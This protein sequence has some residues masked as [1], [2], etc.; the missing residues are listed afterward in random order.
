[1]RARAASVAAVASLLLI[2]L[3]VIAVA[4]QQERHQLGSN[5][6]RPVAFDAV[7]DP[8]EELCQA[9]TDVPRGTGAVLLRLRTSERS[10]P[11]V[12]LTIGDVR[13]TLPA[14]WQDGDV[15]VPVPALGAAREDAAVC[16]AHD[17][18]G[19]IAVAGGPGIGEPARVD[20]R[21][22]RADGMIRLEFAEAGRRSWFPVVG[23]IGDRLDGARDAL[24]G[25]AALPLFVL[26]ALGV[27]GGSL[28][29]VVRE[30]RR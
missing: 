22:V 1:V 8:E 20:G 24:P 11:A 18:P 17:G 29:L 6:V 26:L 3:G 4:A 19:R 28:A 2:A 21:E 7:V 30:G 9:G 12:A 16:L 27:L 23:D 10:G 5:W 15:V 14:G 13:A 25:P